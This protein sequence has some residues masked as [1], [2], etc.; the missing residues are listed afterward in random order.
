MKSRCFFL[1]FIFL[2]LLLQPFGLSAQPVSVEKIREQYFS[3]QEA[4]DGALNLFFRLK[5]LDLSAYPVL[6]AYRGSTSAA[7]AASVPGVNKKLQYF[8]NGKAELE[9]AVKANP[10]NVEIRFLRLATQV[11]APAFLGYHGKVQE[12]KNQIINS[13]VQSNKNDPNAYLYFRIS[14]FLLNSNILDAGE[15]K[16]VLLSKVKF[17]K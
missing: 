6:L 5:P 9:Q 11:N 2:L 10:G 8:M 17:S 3:I 14:E 16:K 13:L 4:K 12:D 1:L 15:R 7:S